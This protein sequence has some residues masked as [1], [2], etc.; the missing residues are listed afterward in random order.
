MRRAVA[1][2][3]PRIVALLADDPLGQ[4]RETGRVD[5]AYRDAFAAIDRDPAHILAVADRD[6]AVIGTLQLTFLPGLARHG[7]WRAQIEAVRVAR[8]LRGRGTGR[9]MFDWAIATARDRGCGLVQL[10]SDGARAGA[11]DFY[12]RLG[13]RPSHVGYKLPL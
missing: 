9:F 1:A 3:L 11:H 10:T 6:G 5:A 12:D 4:G 13:F 2:D 7:M 8:H